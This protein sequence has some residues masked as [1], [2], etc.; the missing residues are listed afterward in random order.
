MGSLPAWHNRRGNITGVTTLG[1]ELYPKR[2]ERLKEA[3]P[4]VTRVAVLRGLATFEPALHAMEG[5]ARS[6]AVELQLFEV[7]EPTAFDSAFVAMTR[8]QADALFVLGDPF[9][10]P[11]HAQIATLAVEHRLPSICA[12]RRAVEMGCLMSYGPSGRD[13]G[14]QIAAYVDK[15]LRG[16]KPA[17]LPVEQA[18]RFEFVINLKTAQ[19]LGL[20]IPPTLLFQ[21]DEVI[22]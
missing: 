1:P 10:A 17:D 19:A 6:L 21:A 7:R 14:P 18:M 11:Y 2:L 13:R 20:T 16:A 12:G 15:I 3:L 8:A 9:F 5:A 4:E 22:K